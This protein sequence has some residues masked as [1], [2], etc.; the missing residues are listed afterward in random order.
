MAERNFRR[1][2]S[3]WLND[4]ANVVAVLDLLVLD[5]MIDVTE[6]CDDGGFVD[7]RHRTGGPE[8]SACAV[9]VKHKPAI[10]VG[11]IVPPVL[12]DANKSIGKRE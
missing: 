8:R 12:L 7:Y 10:S 6:P 1:R 11:P 2:V 4:S 5:L 3:H 9:S